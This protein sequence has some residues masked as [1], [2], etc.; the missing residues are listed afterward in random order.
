MKKIILVAATLGVAACSA[1]SVDDLV[2]DPKLLAKV[3]EQ[4]DE[5][6]RAGKDSN[7]EACKNATAAAKKLIINSASDAINSVKKNAKIVLEDVQRNAPEKL[8]DL[9]KSAE[10]AMQ[11][12]QKNADEVFA[13]AKKLLEDK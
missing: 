12:V 3:V 1:P 9:Q 5:L 11:D 10:Q 4:C 6:A 8:E 13:K 2:N 7:T